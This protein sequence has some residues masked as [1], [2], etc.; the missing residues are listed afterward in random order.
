MTLRSQKCP[1]CAA[2][3]ADTALDRCPYCGANFVRDSARPV[4]AETAVRAAAS[5]R[6]RLARLRAQ[7]EVREA[8]EGEFVV[9]PAPALPIASIG[10]GAVVL[11]IGFAAVAA[12]RGAAGPP[13]VFVL[14]GSFVLFRIFRRRPRTRQLTSTDAERVPAAIVGKRTAIEGR[15]RA[16]TEYFLTLEFEDG[17]RAEYEV[18]GPMYGLFA[19]GD[20]A[21]AYL[22]DS[23]LV[24]LRRFELAAS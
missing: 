20:L 24:R 10:M 11:F 4:T 15:R 7:D 22:H 17:R 18:D 3:L 21:V 12:S 9:E 1:E 8:L 16:S 2:P 13:L 5:T 6:E 23:T 19:E 14:V